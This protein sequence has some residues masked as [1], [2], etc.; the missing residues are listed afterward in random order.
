[1]TTPSGAIIHSAFK[2]DLLVA[3][4]TLGR[5][6]KFRER[7][8]V[9]AEL[10]LGESVLGVLAVSAVT[11]PMHATNRG[12][13]SAPAA[14]MKFVTVEDDVNVIASAPPTSARRAGSGSACTVL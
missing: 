3:A 10:R 1:M 13:A 4:L 2:Y 9:P 5:E 11:G 8:L 6:R 7:L 14:W 12:T